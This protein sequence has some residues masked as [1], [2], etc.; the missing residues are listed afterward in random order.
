MKKKVFF[1]LIILSAVNL[2]AQEKKNFVQ[3]LVDKGVMWSGELSAR[4]SFLNLKGKGFTSMDFTVSFGYNFT[5]FLNAG[6]PFGGETALFEKD[7]ERDWASNG[8]IGLCV[9]IV[10][11]RFTEDG[12]NGL[13]EL[14]L[15]AGSTTWHKYDWQYTYYDCRI[16]LA[17]G[18]TA[19]LQGGFGFRYY[20]ARKSDNRMCLYVS[21]G[22]RIN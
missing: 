7:G 20:D 12:D 10:P 14:Q 6:I 22:Y 19:K 4:G 3:K 1:L 17:Y 11:F 2:N 9:G 18:K 15:A 8:T 5:K 21:L 16:N 13:I